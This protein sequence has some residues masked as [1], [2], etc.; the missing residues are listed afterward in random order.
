MRSIRTILFSWFSIFMVGLFL[1]TG[2]VLY[3]VTQRLLT[4]F[5]IEDNSQALGFIVQNVR[6]HYAKSLQALDKLSNLEGFSPFN[7]SR[8]NENVRHFLENDNLFGRVELYSTDGTLLVEHVRDSDNAYKVKG[9]LFKEWDKRFVDTAKHVVEAGKP[10]ATPTFRHSNGQIHQSYMVPVFDRAHHVTGL[11]VGAVY[12]D[13]SRFRSFMEGLKLGEHNF[14]LMTDV[15]GDLLAQDGLTPGAAH[16]DLHAASVQPQIQQASNAFFHSGRR[17]SDELWID[18]VTFQ[19]EGRY[20]LLALPIEPFK[21]I[22]TLAASDDAVIRKEAV[23]MKWMLATFAVGLVLSFFASSY[24]S[25]V[26]SKPFLLLIRAHERLHRGDLSVRVSY[27]KSNE[28]GELCDSFNRL[29]QKIDKA[30][31]LGNLWGTDSA[32]TSS[33][34]P[35]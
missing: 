26:L 3:S 34:R 2:G 27:D 32:D 24:L 30:R 31:I 17:R 7:P 35:D 10:F 13:E 6:A 20:F 22:L 19:K 5:F 9:N 1:V 11:L 21:L 29:S 12:Y 15:E 25:K 18:S 28:I 4:Q 8:A 16:T 23:L 33:K 14:L